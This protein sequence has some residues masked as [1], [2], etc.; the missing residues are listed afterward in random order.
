MNSFQ[1]TRFNEAWL[2]TCQQSGHRKQLKLNSRAA[3]ET[4]G[5]SAEINSYVVRKALGDLR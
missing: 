3:L 2:R 4:Q 1:W 5:A